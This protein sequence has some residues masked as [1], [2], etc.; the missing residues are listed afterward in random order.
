MNREKRIVKLSVYGIIVNIILVLFKSIV[1]FLSNSIS[2]I[3]DA[4]NNLSDVLS[5]V[6]TIVGTKLASKKPDRE[7][8]F[9]HGRIEFISSI[10]ISIIIM[11]AGFSS[12][13]ESFMKIIKPN[14]VNYNVFSLLVVIMGIFTKLLLGLF[15]KNEGRK[16]NSSSLIASGIDALSDSIISFATLISAIIMLLFKINIDG[17]LG[18]IISFMILKTSYDILKDTLNKIIGVRTDTELIKKL[19]DIINSYSMVHGVYDLA[20]HNYGPDKNIATAHIQV[21]D[22]ITAVEIHHLTRKITYDVFNKLGI[23]LT[24]GIYVSNDPSECKGIKKYIYRLIKK[25]PNIIQMHAFYVDYAEKIITFDLV[26]NFE[27][28]NTDAIIEEIKE[29]LVNKYPEFTFS[30][31]VDIDYCL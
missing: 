18:V 1:G 31:F 11:I 27:E 5:S 16:L 12:L 24:L 3:L 13:K 17:Y 10:I 4:I 28:Q 30:I 26:F 22:S 21:D 25:Y 29:K 7:H 6:I 8:P 19:N 9:G 20:V 14:M 23:V 15:I 2:I